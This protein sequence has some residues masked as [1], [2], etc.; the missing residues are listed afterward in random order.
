MDIIG[1]RG[2][3]E[4]APENTYQ[5]FIYTKTQGIKHV[6]LDVRLSS[7]HELVIIH[8]DTVDRTTN[9][10]GKVESLSFAELSELNATPTSHAWTE[11]SSIPNLKQLFE[12]Q[13]FETY[14]LEVKYDRPERLD[15]LMEKLAALIFQFDMQNRV[16]IT[17]SDLYLLST[18]YRVEPSI[19]RG[20][21]AEFAQ[22]TAI[23]NTLKYECSFLCINW[24][25]CSPEIIQESHQIGL[26]V[27]TWTVNDL[28]TG[29]KLTDWGVD[30]IITDYPTL[31]KAE[32]GET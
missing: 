27:S 3:R 31:F 20:Y 24:K 4:E 5:G 2:A 14:Q 15:I 10:T 25:I 1:H 23:E 30:S 28:E 7:D 29:S 8:D 22:N 18:A 21:V 11:P 32:L 16:T 9:G 6:E 19:A 12:E 13:L 17:S 26:H